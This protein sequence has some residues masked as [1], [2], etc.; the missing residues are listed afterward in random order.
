VTFL[1]ITKKIGSVS[2]WKKITLGAAAC[3]LVGFGI[4]ILTSRSIDTGELHL[5]GA[6]NDQI[7][8]IN[9]AR[10]LADK[11]ELRTYVVLPATLWRK[12]VSDVLYMPGHSA[13]L[14]VVYKLFGVGPF[15]SILPSLI[16]YLVA[17]VAI[18]LIGL[19]LYGMWAGLVAAFLLAVLP[20]AIFFSF[21]A[22]SELT[23]VAAFTAAVAGCLYLPPRLRP[24]LGPFLIA[25][26]FLFRETAAFAVIP[27]GLFFWLE[28][29]EKRWRAVVFVALAVVLMVAI[30]RADFAARRPSML[31]AHIFGNTHAMYD[32]ALAQQAASQVTWRDWI[33][34][35]PGR[36]V[37]NVKDLVTNPEYVP[38]TAVTTYAVL[39]MMLLVLL[40][41]ITRRD[42]F[43]LSVTLLNL[44]I[45]AITLVFVSVNGYR[46]VRYFLFAYALDVVV[47]GWLLVSWFGRITN[48]MPKRRLL[49]SVAAIVIAGLLAG[50][51]LWEVRHMYA[52]FADQDGIDRKM[53]TV[54]EGLNI[55]RSRMLVTSFE[56]TRYRYDHFPTL[57]AML[58]YNEPTLDLLTARYSVGTIIIPY[59]HPL[60]ENPA[61]F[62]SLGFYQDKVLPIDHDVYVV[63]RKGKS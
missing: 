41:A 33:R 44:S 59:G 35:L 62:E 54:L 23:F 55:D 58:P 32:D 2:N 21:T 13:T 43:A 3:L 9:M 48:A 30:F 47:V 46:G 39:A 51:S 25:L 34:V 63:Y 19:R 37:N 53:A 56:C 8:Y 49:M 17:M 10:S 27:L 26:P 11:H 52:F 15:Q 38:G 31:K 12:N 1:E 22:M 36:T 5:Y 29:R 61:K 28:R 60:I 4:L 14:A 40:I 42:K 50:S 45:L 20:A 24:W 7:S 16:S 6:L 18:Y 57:W